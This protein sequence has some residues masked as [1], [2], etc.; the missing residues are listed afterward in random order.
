MNNVLPIRA[1]LKD[2]N[3]GADPGFQVEG[4]WGALKKNCAK[5]FGVFRVKNHDFTPKNHILPIFGG[6][7]PPGSAPALLSFNGALI[8]NTLFIVY[9]LVP[10][11]S[12]G[13]QILEIPICQKNSH[14]S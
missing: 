8:G 10:L 2:N 7:P 3:A 1:P 4:G 13:I 9:T 5:F 11:L 12:I 14:V 6:R